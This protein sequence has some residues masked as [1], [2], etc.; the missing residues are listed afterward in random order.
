MKAV[1]ALVLLALVLLALVLLALVLLA[2]VVLLWWYFR[3]TI[4]IASRW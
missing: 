2:L 1:L 3:P 4:D